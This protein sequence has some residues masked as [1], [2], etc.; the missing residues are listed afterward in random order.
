M[1]LTKK[2]STLRGCVK[3]GKD[4]DIQIRNKFNFSPLCTF[5]I[6]KYHTNFI[7][8]VLQGV[9]WNNF[10]TCYSPEYLGNFKLSLF[11]YDR[12]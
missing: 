11:Y 4:K 6:S 8:Q 3:R 10:N 9:P 2:T 7:V 1:K 12:E 5:C